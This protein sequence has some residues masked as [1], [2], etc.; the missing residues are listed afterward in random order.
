[1]WEFIELC[2]VEMC[3]LMPL[4]VSGGKEWLVPWWETNNNWNALFVNL[5][6]KTLLKELWCQWWWDY[7][8]CE[9]VATP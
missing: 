4:R 3:C 9:E 8:I 5:S 1:M 2:R 6:L 7:T